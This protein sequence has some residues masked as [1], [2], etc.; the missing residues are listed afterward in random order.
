MEKG[1]PT[2][3]NIMDFAKASDRVNHSLL[4]HKLYHYSIPGSENTGVTNFLSDHRQ[5]VV[6][7]GAKSDYISGRSGV[8]QGSVLGPCLFLIYIN[9]LPDRVT[10]PSRLFVDDIIFY[11]FTSPAR[12][13]L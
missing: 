3:A 12:K 8:P 2:D 1:A 10:S 7:D 6:V 5:A 13:V 9:D 11:R 4:V